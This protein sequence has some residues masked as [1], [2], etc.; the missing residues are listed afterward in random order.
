MLSISHL[1]D[2]VT[3]RGHF[4]FDAFGKPIVIDVK[5]PDPIEN[6]GINAFKRAFGMQ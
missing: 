3:Q 5:V 1:Y 4:K 6:H 2:E